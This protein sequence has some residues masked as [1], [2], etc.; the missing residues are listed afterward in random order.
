MTRS[1][2]GLG[3]A[4]SFSPSLFFFHLPHRQKIKKKRKWSLRDQA[5]AGKQMQMKFQLFFSQ[6][7]F[8]SSFNQKKIPQSHTNTTTTTTKKN[9]QSKKHTRK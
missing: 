1:E 4:F 9:N 2:R 7:F 8:I 6:V 3:R 5:A